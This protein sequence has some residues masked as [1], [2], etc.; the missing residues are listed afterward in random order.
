MYH[1]KHSGWFIYEADPWIDVVAKTRI[2]AEMQ[3]RDYLKI[4]KICLIKMVEDCRSNYE[5]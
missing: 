4:D 5:V 2:C 3:P 1:F